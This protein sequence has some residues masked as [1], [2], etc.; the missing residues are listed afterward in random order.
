MSALAQ[1]LVAL[2]KVH[3]SLIVSWPDTAHYIIGLIVMVE[4]GTWVGIAYPI[5]QN[6]LYNSRVGLKGFYKN[7][8]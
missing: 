6:L 2:S 3:K 5:F 1:S 8:I 7:I 4:V